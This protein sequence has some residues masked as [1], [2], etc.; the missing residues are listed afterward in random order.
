M[1]VNVI[2]QLEFELSYYGSAVHRFNEDTLLIEYLVM[3]SSTWNN[4]TVY[5][6]KCDKSF[7]YIYITMCKQIVNHIYQPLCSDRIWHKVNF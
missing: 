5:K 1:K 6:R 2:A 3:H 4:L 7:M